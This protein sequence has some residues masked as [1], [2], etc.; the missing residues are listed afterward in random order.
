MHGIVLRVAPKINNSH[1]SNMILLWWW[2][3]YMISFTARCL[4]SRSAV[5]YP[6][7]RNKT[8]FRDPEQASASGRAWKSSL[9]VLPGIQCPLSLFTKAE[10]D[11]APDPGWSGFQ[12]LR[13][14]DLWVLPSAR[15]HSKP[16]TDSI[17]AWARARV[18]VR[19]CAHLRPGGWASCKT[20]T[21]A[22]EDLTLA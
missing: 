7:V 18:H 6:R 9:N 4:R 3:T 16:E 17:Y 21:Q 22:W 13:S 1:C 14:R 15:A 5:I 20:H 8:F 19:V 2:N 12:S 10:Q 11:R